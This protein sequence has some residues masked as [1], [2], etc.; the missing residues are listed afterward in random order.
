MKWNRIFKEYNLKKIKDNKI[1]TLFLFVS[2]ILAVSISISIPLISEQTKNFQK[3]QVYQINGADLKIEAEY[4][5]DKFEEQLKKLIDAG[6]DI[7][8]INIYGSTIS[9]GKMQIYS[10]LLCGNYNLN[11]REAI[12]SE[13]LAAGLNLEVGDNVTLNAEEYKII[14]IEEYAQGVD[15]QSEMVGYAKVSDTNTT[16]L[17]NTKTLYFINRS[18]IDEL[19]KELFSIEKNYIYTTVEDKAEEL[20]NSVEVN[21]IALNI[22]NTIS[23]L[24]TIVSVISSIYMI[25]ERRKNDITIMKMLS[26]GSHSIKKAFWIEIFSTSI[27]AVIIGGAVSIPFAQ[28]LLKRSNI[29]SHLNSDCYK[30]IIQGIILFSFIYGVLIFL[31]VRNIDSILALEVSRSQVPNRK[32][33]KKTSIITFVLIS[34]IFYAVYV[35]NLSILISSIAIVLC[36]II[37]MLIELFLC[38]ILT[39]FLA[40]GK[41]LKY[42]MKN[43][44]ANKFSILLTVVSISLTMLFLLIGFTFDDI[45]GESYRNTIEDSINYNYIIMAE[46]EQEFEKVINKSDEVNGYTKLLKTQAIIIEEQDNRIAA[47]LNYIEEDSY[48]V[49]YNIIEG[50]DVIDCRNNEIII[51][52]WLEDSCDLKLDQVLQIECEGQIQEYIIKGIYEAGEI[53]QDSILLSK[54]NMMINGEISVQYLVNLSDLEILEDMSGIVV[55]GVDLLSSSVT[56][57][58]EKYLFIFKYLCV[59]S[60]IISLLFNIN[61][62]YM[63]FSKDRKDYVIIRALGIG[64]GFLYKSFVVKFFLILSLSL[65]MSMGLYLFVVS[66]LINL[67]FGWSIM[68]RAN[69]IILPLIIAIILV[70]CIFVIPF[71]LVKQLKSFNE[72][73]NV[74]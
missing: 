34:M 64:K 56:T 1:T 31:S 12:I 20:N 39:I 2:I 17:N 49:K 63:L 38:S 60:I 15:S 5:S 58:F 21:A 54:E 35:R 24:M 46:D 50:Q 70:A 23:Y 47:T 10:Y 42:T 65:F 53:N 8:T 37:F 62:I 41:L 45:L 27:V 36:I 55:I 9:K 22:L 59:I 68:I 72:L 33:S 19:K 71:T 40:K 6:E 74:D 30:L 26:L 13:K 52:D 51:S 3:E 32:K 66:V 48:G 25:I 69:S 43:L 28:W 16:N 29:A 61:I 67:L 14:G 4:K 18:N 73:R 57:Y 7:I 11:N 44:K